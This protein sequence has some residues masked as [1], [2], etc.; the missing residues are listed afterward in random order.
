MQVEPKS[1]NEYFGAYLADEGQKTLA[2]LLRIRNVEIFRE[3]KR[4]HIMAEAD[5]MMAP[6]DIDALARSLEE[7]LGGG[8]SVE[9]EAS[10]PQTADAETIEDAWS[11][12]KEEV[13]RT[14]PML[15]HIFRNADTSVEG[16]TVRL[17]LTRSM[18]DLV[19]HTGEIRLLEE[20]LKSMVGVPVI[21]ELSE[22]PE[23]SEALQAQREKR[24]AEGI[25]QA[26]FE[27]EFGRAEKSG[28]TED[29]GAGGI[30]E[31]AFLSQIGD[32]VPANEPDAEAE[33]RDASVTPE[34]AYPEAGGSSA[35]VE[36]HAIEALQKKA[37]IEEYLRAYDEEELAKQKKEA[38]EDGDE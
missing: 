25:S 11:V 36:E 29:A 14:H 27:A 8:I 10:M 7:G 26:L 22:K 28:S 38:G 19:R 20:S 3:E 32:G 6:S 21:V 15:G 23:D 34:E 37:K 9:L 13:S 35:A 4:M 33:R 18:A 2:S 12:L 30:L 16:S 31:E 24:E 5:Q 1:L 17:E